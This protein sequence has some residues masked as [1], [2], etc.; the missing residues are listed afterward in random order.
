MQI[1]DLR[2]ITWSNQKGSNT[3]GILLKTQIN[4]KYLKLGSF[5]GEF[6]YNREPLFEVLSSRVGQQLNLNVL[7]YDLILVKIN[8]NGNQLVTEASISTEYKNNEKAIPIEEFTTPNEGG[9]K[10]LKTLGLINDYK[11]LVIFDF[12]I[13]N[14]DRHGKNIEVLLNDKG[15]YR[16]A[17]AFDNSF[18]ALTYRY[19]QM[20][21]K[22]FENYRYNDDTKVNNYLGNNNL[23]SNLKLFKP[24]PKL[25]YLNR[26]EL[27]QG[28]GK[29]T[30]RTFRNNYYN[31]IN[32]RIKKYNEITNLL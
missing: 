18:T 32:E 29:T 5:S 4:N 14:M 13:C 7:K 30:T 10:K 8:I 25:K 24:L 28:I 2:N 6:F 19:N 9:I 26:E 16:L 31:F 1:Y 17:L 22:D 27:F 3:N 20:L 15:K 11:K 23:E 12:I 21:N